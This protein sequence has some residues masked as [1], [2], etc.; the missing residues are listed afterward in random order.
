MRKPA[1]SFSRLRIPEY[2][3]FPDNEGGFNGE[4]IA[5]TQKVSR[6]VDAI[7]AINRGDHA[8]KDKDGVWRQQQ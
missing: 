7:D 1:E 6:V 2:I 3:A 5:T 8:I 4:I